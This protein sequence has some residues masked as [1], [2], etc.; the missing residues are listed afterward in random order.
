MT[1]IFKPP[2]KPGERDLFGFN[3]STL[4]LSAGETISSAQ[5]TVTDAAGVSVP[6]FLDGA[7]RVL[8]QSAHQM[9]HIPEDS[10][11]GGYTLHVAV[12][13]PDRGPLKECA[14]FYVQRC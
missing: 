6:D 9:L 12:I 8:A 2:I 7:P 3:F 4:P 10:P 13:T 1:L 5:F 11:E 14:A